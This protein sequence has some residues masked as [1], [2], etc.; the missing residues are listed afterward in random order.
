MF[1]KTDLSLPDAS[2]Y[3]FSELGKKLMPNYKFINAGEDWNVDYLKEAKLKW[4]P[5]AI[6]SSYSLKMKTRK[7]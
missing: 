1:E 2:T 7:T 3:V 6:K 5:S 4:K